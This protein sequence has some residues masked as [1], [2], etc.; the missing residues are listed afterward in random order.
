MYIFAVST[1]WKQFLI[2]HLSFIGLLLTQENI[3]GVLT[4]IP[5]LI[6]ES[7]LHISQVRISKEAKSRLKKK[8]FR[9]VANLTKWNIDQQT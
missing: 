8:R 1:S 6:S 9:F 7:D 5:P 2:S 4:E 3:S